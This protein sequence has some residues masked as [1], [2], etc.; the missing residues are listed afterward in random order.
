MSIKSLKDK[1]ISVLVFGRYHSFDLVNGLS[2]YFKSI[3]LITSFPN[4]KIK[5][6]GTINATSVTLPI[7]E[8]IN[9][10]ISILKLN[11]LITE[12]YI[13]RHF[14][15]LAN[16]YLKDSDV[17]IGWSSCSLPSIIS[18]PSA[19]FILERGSAHYS[20]QMKLLKDE[21]DKYNLNFEPDY[22]SWKQ[23]LLEYELCDYISVPSNFVKETFISNGISE[24]KIFLNPYGCNLTEFFP[25]KKKDNKFRVIF[26]GLGSI[27]KGF[28]VLLQAL[29][30]L[31]KDGLEIELIHAGG[32]DSN[33]NSFF[34]KCSN[35]N[36][37]PVGN[38]AQSKLRY[39]YSQSSIFVLPSIQDGFGMVITQAMACGLPI[40]VSEN[41][42]G[43][44]IL[45]IENGCGFTVKPGDIIDLKNKINWFYNNKEES[46]KMGKL[47]LKAVEQNFTWDD[48][49]K[50]YSLFLSRL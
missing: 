17:I 3:Q 27:Q 50:R 8:Y 36:Y 47:S 16:Y 26:C 20:S 29:E 42:G 32:I 7:F 28:H 35:V 14:N 25:E 5:Q 22:N 31:S 45:E 49:A 19:V 40:I 43:P 11:F 44:D 1:K 41:T 13:K 33:M 37:Q 15:Y 38:I 9:R 30:I 34:G 4:F 48:Y 10:S 6:W 21:H 18:N 2:G 39:Y 24:S 12:T 46:G 23:E